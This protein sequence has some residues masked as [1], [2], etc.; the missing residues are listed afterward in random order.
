MAKRKFRV[1]RLYNLI[2]NLLIITSL[3]GLL[4]SALMLYISKLA[5]SNLNK[6]DLAVKFPNHYK[7]IKFQN[8][9][10]FLNYVEPDY[11]SK[12]VTFDYSL[13]KQ[14]YTKEGIKKEEKL[15][16]ESAEIEK[17]RE[18]LKQM[19]KL[20]TGYYDTLQLK[21]ERR[22]LLHDISD[23]Q[24]VAMT[25]LFSAIIIQIVF[26]GMVWLYRYLFP[27]SEAK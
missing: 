1:E 26:W 7:E 18:T 21:N 10:D 14:L 23:S 19:I 11:T 13:I 27:L 15:R 2:R 20:P 3:L 6:I 9:D 22:L 8:L 5:Q 25:L 4:A 17:S 24:H 16:K 12:P